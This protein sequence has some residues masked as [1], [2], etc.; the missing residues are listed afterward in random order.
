MLHIGEAV[1]KL[2]TGMS[3][4]SCCAGQVELRHHLRKEAGKPYRTL[5]GRLSP[6][7]VASV[8]HASFS[9]QGHRVGAA[10]VFVVRKRY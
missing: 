8:L 2:T 10:A 4:R 9:S 7:A 6:A 5:P 1:M 3:A